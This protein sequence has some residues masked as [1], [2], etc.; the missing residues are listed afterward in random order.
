MKFL[1]LAREAPEIIKSYPKLLEIYV[2]DS[3]EELSNLIEILNVYLS[4]GTRLERVALFSAS[5]DR[6]QQL[7]SVISKDQSHKLM[8]RLV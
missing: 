6:L 4:F 2:V 7:Q 8:L 1:T 5:Q 3:G